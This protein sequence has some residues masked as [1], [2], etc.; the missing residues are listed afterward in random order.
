MS[1]ENEE[2]VPMFWVLCFFIFFVFLFFWF[3]FFFW[4]DFLIDTLSS[5]EHYRFIPLLLL[6]QVIPSYHPWHTY[7]N[8]TL[9]LVLA[10]RTQLLDSSAVGHF[11][12]ALVNCPSFSLVGLR[13][14]R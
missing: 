8:I 12:F 7:N 14:S 6:I 11:P 2:G 10:T 4:P 1:C 13:L 5:S 9:Y 3:D